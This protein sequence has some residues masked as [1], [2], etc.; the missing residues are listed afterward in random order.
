MPMLLF[1]PFIPECAMVSTTLL[2]VNKNTRMG[3]SIKMTAEAD[4]MPT[5]DMVF[6]MEICRKIAGRFLNCSVN[7]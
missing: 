6:D 4:E 1:Y 3:G 5:V 2:C 7:I